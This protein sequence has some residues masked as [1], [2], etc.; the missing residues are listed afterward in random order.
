MDIVIVG[1][2]PAGTTAAVLLAR[3]GHR[4]TLVDRDPG[5]VP[6]TP[7]ERVGV[8]Q[9]HLPHAF[10]APGVQVLQQ[11]VPELR[12][13]LVDAGGE[14]VAP[15][16][17]PDFLAELVASM[18]IRRSVMERTMWEFADREPGITRV[19]GHADGLSLDGTSVVGV[20]VDGTVHPADL[21]VDATGK[22]GRFAAEHRPDFEG[23]DCGFAYASRLFRL[24]DGA[25]PGPVNGGPGHVS[26]HQ[27]FLNL[28]FT[29]D[30]GTFSVLLVRESRDDGLAELRH[31][32]SFM[33]A[34]ACL[35]AAAVWTDPAR[36]EPIDDVRAGAGL[37]NQYRGQALG[38]TGLLSIGDATCATNPVAARGMSLA[39]QAAAAVADIVA[40]HPREAWADALDAWSLANLRPWFADHVDFDHVTHKLWAGETIA[41]SD[42]IS[43][44]LVADAASRRP[45]FMPTLGPFLGMLT[46][47]AS[48]DGLRDEVRQMLA[49]GWRP[50]AYPPPA[51]DDLVTAMRA[52]APL[53][54]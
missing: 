52:P 37:V 33:R 32:E 7:W 28:I 49:D 11:R 14:I 35:P 19:R 46:P 31:E 24:R 48:I 29:H 54:A 2:G 53:P 18:H 45:E 22:A 47:P 30:A 16:G 17:T 13:A 40:E 4:V 12:Q 1:S 3:Q 38:I 27:G 6:G 44:A 23:G 36:S 15:P 41:P 8:M 51:R 25:E 10:R 26:E 34:A 21:V 5:P 20:V 39:M 43:W 9:F 42:P 50:R